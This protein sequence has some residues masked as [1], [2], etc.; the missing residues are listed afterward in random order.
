[1]D[2]TNDVAREYAEKGAPEG[3]VIL[4]QYQ[5]QGR[6]R[7]MRSWSSPKGKNI[8]LSLILRPSLRLEEVSLITVMSSVTVASLLREEGFHAFIKWP[9]DIYVE[10]KKVAGILTEMKSEKNE[11][12]HVI[13]GIGLNV[14]MDSS[15]CPEDIQKTVTSLAM[16]SGH[17]WDR[18]VLVR[19][20]LLQLEKTYEHLQNQEYD[21]LLSQWSRLSSLVGHWVEVKVSDKKWEGTVL[22][23]D[24]KGA[25]LLRREGGF[26][27]AFLSGDVKIL[28][29]MSV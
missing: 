9:N 18:T 13:V 5:R 7:M 25:L 8:L 23:T 15:E 26:I 16:L 1:M 22:G 4:A 19:E 14:N 27:E 10:G 21:F 24:A 12:K 3:T 29:R 28:D 20:L 11:V 6:G 2:S 17:L